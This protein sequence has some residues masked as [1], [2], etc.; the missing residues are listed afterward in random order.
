MGLSTGQQRRGLGLWGPRFELLLCHLSWPPLQVLGS[1]FDRDAASRLVRLKEKTHPQ[2]PWNAQVCTRHPFEGQLSAR[3]GESG[4]GMALGARARPV[5]AQSPW[6]P[7]ALGEPRG[8]F[9]RGRQRRP[10]LERSLGRW[11]RLTKAVTT[12]L[13]YTL[14]QNVALHYQRPRNF[15]PVSFPASHLLPWGERPF[16]E[17]QPVASSPNEVWPQRGGRSRGRACPLACRPHLGPAYRLHL[18]RNPALSSGMS[19]QSSTSAVC[20]KPFPRSHPH[21]TCTLPPTRQV[22]PS[23]QREGILP[24]PLGFSSL[25]A[26]QQSLGACLF[27]AAQK[28]EAGSTWG[29]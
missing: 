22:V 13:G 8:C 15:S 21:H 26:P 20:L 25:L 19:C 7:E 24:A 4:Q 9:W 17:G 11:P 2:G 28:P 16:F 10:G 29:V 14:Q 18:F 12:P 27:Q 23:H 6:A 1:S 3:P 5:C